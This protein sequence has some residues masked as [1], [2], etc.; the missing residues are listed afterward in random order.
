M[1]TPA[2]AL[3]RCGADAQPRRRLFE[4]NPKVTLQVRQGETHARLACRGGV[5]RGVGR[6]VGRSVRRTLASVTPGCGPAS[7]RPVRPR[8][9][10]NARVPMPATRQQQPHSQLA[11]YWRQARAGL[12]REGEGAVPAGR[13]PGLPVPLRRWRWP[14]PAPPLADL[15]PRRTSPSDPSSS[16]SSAGMCMWQGQRH[17]RMDGA[18]AATQSAHSAAAEQDALRA[19]PGGAA[20][21]YPTPPPVPSHPR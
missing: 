11:A 21:Q 20:L 16:S 4:P 7:N 9:R 18:D 14:P 17:A 13:S 15:P 5:R 3:Q 10:T 1:C 8:R 12:A 6:S 19:A 2:R